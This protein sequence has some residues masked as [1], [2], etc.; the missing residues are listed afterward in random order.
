[1][2]AMDGTG[3]DR[4]LFTD[5]YQLTMLQ[6]YVAEG[7]TDTAVFTLFVRRLPPARRYL[8]ACGLAT[9]VEQLERLHF[10]DADLAYLRSLGKFSEVCLS[11]LSRFRFSGEVHAVAE[12]TPVFANEPI[13]EVV[14]PL[15]EAQLVETLVMNQMH[16]QTL[17]ASK[18]ARVV[19]AAAGRSVI[20]FG[21]R[22][23]HGIDAAIAGA[24]AVYIAG[25]AATSNLVAGRQ[26]GIPVAGTM[27][28]SY[29]QAHDDEGDA[30]RRFAR[31][32]PD[33]VLLVDTYDT[34]EAVGRVIEL[35]RTTPPVRVSA[36]RL[37]SGDLRVLAP[38]VRHRLDAAGLR[39]IRIMASSE[40]DEYEIRALLDA[41]VPIDG[42]G[43]GTQMGVS[44][45]APALEIVYK[46]V[47]Y[48]GRDRT[49]LSDKKPV[50]PGRK[51][52]FRQ[53]ADGRATGDV[54]ARADEELS[55]RPLLE[56]VMHHGR[57][58]PALVADVSAI[59]GRAAAELA[60]L[61]REV[62]CL[63][64]GPAGYPVCTSAALERRHQDAR[65][66]VA[67]PAAR[68]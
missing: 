25:A 30:F 42:F 52:V 58:T 34:L 13:L 19:A 63:D 14:A 46:L 24:R 11:W 41:G 68:V 59:R 8:L 67:T 65:R 47:A 22:R 31:E 49:K 3:F 62:R 66:R 33:T 44:A 17:L 37:D 53:E 64:P 2:S 51:Q 1:M 5:L 9:V 55:G 48:A 28:H 18:A 12:G 10:T 7:A 60:R 26:F 43:V 20:D 23:M 50:L 6:A 16:V 21:M 45:D 61:P 27:A 4:A 15:P 32:F 36:V 29:V 39:H 56:M 54:I 40:L 35:V 57:R 38:Q